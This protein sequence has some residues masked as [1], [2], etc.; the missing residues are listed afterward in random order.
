[1]LSFTSSLIWTPPTSQSSDSHFGC[2]YRLSFRLPSSMTE[3]SHVHTITIYKHAVSHDPDSPIECSLPFL[4]LWWQV[5]HIREALQLQWCNE[6]NLFAFATAYLL[7]QK[8]SNISV[9]SIC[10][11]SVFNLNG[12][13]DGLDFHQLAIVRF[14]AHQKT[15]DWL[16]F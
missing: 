8:S 13:L 15:R 14:V 10:C 1:M 3:T 9:T 11:L 7:T 16:K 12:K 2:P 5:C 4:P 6:A